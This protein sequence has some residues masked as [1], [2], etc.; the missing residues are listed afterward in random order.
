MFS[1]WQSLCVVHTSI[2]TSFPFDNL[3]IYKRI[4]FKICICIST[5]NVALGI[6]NGQMSMIYHTVVALVN[7]QK[8][9]FGL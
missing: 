8:M 3:S 1:R 9:V 5:N 7:V 6:V 4:S 2:C